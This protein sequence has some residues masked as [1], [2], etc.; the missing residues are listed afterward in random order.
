MRVCLCV[1]VCA[2]VRVCVCKCVCV[3]SHVVKTEKE[4]KREKERSLKE[5]DVSQTLKNCI[6]SSGSIQ[7]VD[8]DS[9]TEHTA[10]AGRS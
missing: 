6:G 7:P 9:V 3:Y 2:C 8:T 5:T 1:R 10:R 4:R